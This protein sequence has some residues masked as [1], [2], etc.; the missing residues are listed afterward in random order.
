MLEMH[1]F[2]FLSKSIALFYGI[3]FLGWLVGL[4]FG[5]AWG[6]ATGRMKARRGK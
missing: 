1:E 6:F 4:F 3:F 5:F 2:F